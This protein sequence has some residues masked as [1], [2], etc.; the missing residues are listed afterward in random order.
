MRLTIPFVRPLHPEWAP[1]SPDRRILE[2]LL[3]RLDAAGI[4]R[5]DVDVCVSERI[6][7]LT[8]ELPTGN[9]ISRIARIAAGVPGVMHIETAVRARP[10]RWRAGAARSPRAVG[11]EAGSL[12]SAFSTVA[13]TGSSPGASGGT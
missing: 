8:G 7:T 13:G 1:E 10:P 12:P 2:T 3:D 6:V 5:A 9:D 4:D 11:L